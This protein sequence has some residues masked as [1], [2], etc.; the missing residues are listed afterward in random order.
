ML[1]NDD[2]TKSNGIQLHISKRIYLT[3][4]SGIGALSI[5]IQ[6]NPAECSVMMIQQNPTKAKKPI[7][8]QLCSI[9]IIQLEQTKSIGIQDNPSYKIIW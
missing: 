4:Q 8:I 2:P 6:Q 7:E 3:K 9:M 1:F 5:M